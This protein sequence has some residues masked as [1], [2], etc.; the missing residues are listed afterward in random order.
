MSNKEI[1]LTEADMSRLIEMA[2]EDRTPFEAILK[3]YQLDEPSLMRIMQAQLKPSSY[4]LWRKR[5]KEKSSKHLKLRSPD[6]KRDHCKTQ[7]KISR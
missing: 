6:I 1:V 3:T 4:R 5:V 7:Y 2:W